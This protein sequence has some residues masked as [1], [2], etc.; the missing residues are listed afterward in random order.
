MVEMKPT[1]NLPYHFMH[2][3]CIEGLRHYIRRQVDASYFV[4]EF[5]QDS[6][7]Q[8]D[9]APLL[10]PAPEIHPKCIPTY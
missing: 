5:L 2:A 9:I 6:I 10:L 7:R 3:L 1:N 8:R 4:L